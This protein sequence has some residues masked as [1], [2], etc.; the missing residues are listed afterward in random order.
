MKRLDLP[1]GWRFLDFDLQDDREEEMRMSPIARIGHGRI[2]D[3][4]DDPIKIA[5]EED[6]AAACRLL[7]EAARVRVG[8]ERGCGAE[9]NRSAKGTQHKPTARAELATFGRRRPGGRP[10][11]RT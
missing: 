10:P 1:N 2:L 6:R 7:L 3:W 9:G 11:R 4:P 5:E 8:C